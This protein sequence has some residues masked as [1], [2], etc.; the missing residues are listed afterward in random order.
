MFS[1]RHLGDLGI[2]PQDVERNLEDCFQ[3]GQAWECVLL[4][5]EADIFLAARGH[6]NENRNALV[7]GKTCLSRIAYGCAWR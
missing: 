6:E 4:L 7:S 3:M 2:T 1:D 5:D